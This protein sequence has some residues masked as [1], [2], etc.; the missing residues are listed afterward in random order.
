[1]NMEAYIT[2]VHH[3]YG[4]DILY[5]GGSKTN[6]DKALYEYVLRWW[7]DIEPLLPSTI[8]VGDITQP[9]TE[10]KMW[11]RI[12]LYFEIHPDNECGRIDTVNLVDMSS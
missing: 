3:N 11:Q 10:D 8:D 7:H 4:T 9:A 5:A 1:M 12:N 2:I 6:A